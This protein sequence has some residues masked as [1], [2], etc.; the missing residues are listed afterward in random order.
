MFGQV[1]VKLC[2]TLTLIVTTVTQEKLQVTCLAQGHN[3]DS[4]IVISASLQFQTHTD[5]S[6]SLTFWKAAQET[7]YYM[8]PLP[9]HT[10][11]TYFYITAAI[12]EIKQR[13]LHFIVLN[14]FACS[15]L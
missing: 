5:Y 6:A 13:G 9:I 8:T 12:D 2:R 10:Q 3:G 7:K 1:G 14:S 15:L 11:L 4:K